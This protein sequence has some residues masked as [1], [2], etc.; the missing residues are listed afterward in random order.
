[1]IVKGLFF[2]SSIPLSWEYR[3]KRWGIREGPKEREGTR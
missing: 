3:I 1:M 2:F